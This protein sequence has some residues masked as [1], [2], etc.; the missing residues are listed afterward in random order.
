MTLTNRERFYKKHNIPLD[1]SLS[2][3]QIATLSKMPIKAL[4]EVYKR[5]MGAHKTNLI[6][7]R[8]KSTGQKNISAPASQK[9]SPQQWSYGRL[10]SFV[11]KSPSTYYGSDVDIKNKYNI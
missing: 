11:M 4:E 6:S 7:V 5:G 10:Y 2:L 8:L 1:K 9:M 3:K